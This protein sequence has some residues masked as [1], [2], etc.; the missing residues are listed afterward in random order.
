[1][2]DEMT[3]YNHLEVAKQLIPNPYANDTADGCEDN[4]PHQVLRTPEQRQHRS[5]R[6]TNTDT[7]PEQQ[8]I[9]RELKLRA[10]AK[11]RK[12]HKAGHA[13]KDN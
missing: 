9:H 8:F 5:N 10:N 13:D 3:K 11:R 7:Y 2:P 4:R 12:H 1:M 6:A